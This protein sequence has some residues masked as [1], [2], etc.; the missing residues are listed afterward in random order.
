MHA[1]P[2]V[3]VPATDVESTMT[4]FSTVTISWSI[5]GVAYTP[6]TYAVKYGTNELHLTQRSAI[7]SSSEGTTRYSLEL[8]QLQDST[9][10]YFQVESNNT[11]GS[12]SSEIQTFEVQNACKIYN[13]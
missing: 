12:I 10:Y 2:R 3:P 13:Q 9:Q 6:E 1:G 8:T 4:S 11:V 5:S 7:I